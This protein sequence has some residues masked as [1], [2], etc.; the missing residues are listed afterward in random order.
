MGLV[1]LTELAAHFLSLGWGMMTLLAAFAWVGLSGASV[2][3][4]ARSTEDR[5]NGLIPVIGTASTLAANAFPK[6][7]GTVSGNVTVTGTHAVNG[8]M[9]VGG[10]HT[11]SGQI[12]GSTVSLTGGMT[13]YGHT[14]H[15]NV[16]VDSNV[17]VGGTL[18]GAGGG[19]VE[20]TAAHVGGPMVVDGN[21]TFSGNI[22]GGP[23]V[24][25]GQG[26]VGVPSLTSPSANETQ[27]FNGVNGCI[28]RLNSSGLI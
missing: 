19:T 9:T 28:S 20:T 2:A 6:T 18:T 21:A 23:V 7:G 22:N 17:A 8:N 11:V 10:S 1:A 3:A 15:G 14:S 24:V 12:N 13:D 26:A 4:K 27:L 5:V 25:G 16:S